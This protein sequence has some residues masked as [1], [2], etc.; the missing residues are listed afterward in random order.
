M[1]SRRWSPSRSGADAHAA[2][3]ADHVLLGQ[4]PEHELAVG[5]GGEAAA[6]ALEEHAHLVAAG[7]HQVAA[8]VAVDVAD[9]EPGKIDVAL[10]LALAEH[11]TGPQRHEVVGAVPDVEPRH[12]LARGRQHD[13]LAEPRHQQAQAV[14]ESGDGHSQR[15]EAPLV[16]RH[17]RGRVAGDDEIAARRR[18]PG[19][20]QRRHPVAPQQQEFLA[21]QRV[22]IGH[23]VGR[24]AVRQVAHPVGLGPQRPVVALE[25]EAQLAPLARRHAE[26]RH[27]VDVAPAVAVEIREARRR[28]AP[29]SGQLDQPERLLGGS[30]GRGDSRGQSRQPGDALHEPL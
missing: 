20:R 28:G 3:A 6:L 22:E 29:G 15:V 25:V 5:S 13:A 11:R 24:G 19:K 23:V 7:G 16:G 9:L 8:S 26:Q 1:R 17:R 18:A 12:D 21:G 30:A 10:D 4:A 2:R 14:A 27:R